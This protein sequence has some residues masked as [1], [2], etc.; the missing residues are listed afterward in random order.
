LHQENL[1]QPKK[2][3]FVMPDMI[4]HPEHP[5]ITGFRLSPE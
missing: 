2:S 1:L 5:K 3:E 4:R